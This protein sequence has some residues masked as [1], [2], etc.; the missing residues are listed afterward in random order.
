M[1]QMVAAY[2]KKRRFRWHVKLFMHLMYITLNNAHIT[3]LEYTG[4]SKTEYP[5]LN[6][7][8]ET[9]EELKPKHL[10]RTTQAHV[11]RDREIL[12]VSVFTVVPKQRSGARNVVSGCTLTMQVVGARAGPTGM[13]TS[14]NLCTQ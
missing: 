13:V 9:I 4:K 5:F 14:S 12:G 6:M 8:L 7:L 1:D 10:V 3:L 2:Y 11:G